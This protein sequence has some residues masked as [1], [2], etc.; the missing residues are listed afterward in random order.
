MSLLALVGWSCS[1]DSGSG[2]PGGG[3]AEAE[4][5]LG[6]RATGSQDD[7]EL[8]RSWWVMLVNGSGKICDLQEGSCDAP[9]KQ[10]KVRVKADAGTYTLYAFANWT[11]DQVAEAIGLSKGSFAK[12]KTIGDLQPKS[13]RLESQND[14]NAPLAMSG[15]LPRVV[16]NSRQ[17]EAFAIEVVRLWAKLDFEFKNESKKSIEVTEVKFG[18]LTS[19]PAPLFYSGSP[20]SPAI[21]EGCSLSDDVFFSGSISLP[22]NGTSINQPRYI[23]ET[24]ATNHLTGKFHI[25]VRM[26]REGKDVEELYALADDLNGIN[27][28]DHIRVPVIFTDYTLELKALFYPPIGGY[29][30]QIEEK[31]EEFYVSFG[32]KGEFALNVLMHDV[33]NGTYLSPDQ[34]DIKIGTVSDP[35]GILVKPA[36]KEKLHF[37]EE[38]LIAGELNANKGIAV[39]EIEAKVKSQGAAAKVFKRK[40]YIIRK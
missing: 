23:R 1:S 16:L 18:P 14:G 17:Q 33:D 6:T 10:D 36:N 15:V 34:L 25:K 32:S 9:S 20:E 12:G 13:L 26:R 5:T 19:G 38:G 2:E 3:P 31:N 21:M 28:N 24:L 29:P 7:I 4:I 22:A 30:P 39:A 37:N 11:P 35:S 27:R 40:F 8:M